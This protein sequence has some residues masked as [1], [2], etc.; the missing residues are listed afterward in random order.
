MSQHPAYGVLRP[1][2]PLAS[3]LLQHNPGHMTLE[4]TNTWVLAAPEAPDRIVVDPGEDDG[5]HLERL[6]D[7]PPVAVVLLTHHHHDHAGGAGRFA[8][9][10]GAPVRALAPE[11]T[12]GADPLVDGG[13]VAAAGVE[14]QVLATPGHT[15]DSTSLLL[16]GP[17]GGPA[18]LSGDT[19]LGRGTAVIAQPDGGLGPY[20]DSL[21][22]LAALPA[23][24]A[25]LPGH[26]PELPDAAEISRQY[27]EHR[28][29]RLDQV[30]TAL[31]RLGPDASARQV[32]EVVYAD[33]DR[34][35]WDAAEWSV[36]AQLDYLRG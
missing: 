34:K 28:E 25:V 5:E 32:V 16:H 6:A 22:R 19:I 31:E 27:L 17:S 21:G 14:L 11:L 24:T 10:T 36:T 35:L 8:E 20:L 18:L 1:V 12:A 7:G 30:R 4:G 2:H 3:V 26:G 33:V 23:G 9:L 29:Q 13:T 15:A